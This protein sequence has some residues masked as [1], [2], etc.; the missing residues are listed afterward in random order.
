[1]ITENPDSLKLLGRYQSPEIIAELLEK[2]RKV[3]V[4]SRTIR[5]MK[6]ITPEWR[7]KITAAVTAEL[8]EI[9]YNLT[10]GVSE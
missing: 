1:M 3:N 8:V 5:R 10:H 9:L 2:H 4:S 7:D 6:T